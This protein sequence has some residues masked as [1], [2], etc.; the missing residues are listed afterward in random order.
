[1]KVL[2]EHGINFTVFFSMALVDMM[3][4]QSVTKQ[5]HIFTTKLAFQTQTKSFKRTDFCNMIKSFVEPLWTQVVVVQICR[6]LFAL[7]KYCSLFEKHM[8]RLCGSPGRGHTTLLPVCLCKDIGLRY[9]LQWKSGSFY[10]RLRTI[11]KRMVTVKAV[12]LSSDH[13][14]TPS[15]NWL[16]ALH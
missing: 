4:A 11:K 10:K 6:E 15:E 12:N 5:L 16:S 3:E 2:V 14:S 13:F 7:Q 1:M 8:G 9:S